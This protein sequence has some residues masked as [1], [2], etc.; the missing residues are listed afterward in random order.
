MPE[1]EGTGAKVSR[2][3]SSNGRCGASLQP[4]PGRPAQGGLRLRPADRAGGAGGVAPDLGGAS[5]R[6]C[7]ARGARARRAP[8]PC[9]RGTRL[10]GGRLQRRRRPASL[11]GR[12]CRRVALAGI[13]PVPPA[14]SRGRGRLLSRRRRRRGAHPA[15]P[16][17]QPPSTR[18]WPMCE[19]RNRPVAPSRSPRRD[20]TTCCWVGRPERENDACQRLGGIC[21]DCRSRR[22]SR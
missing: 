13:E 18:T 5:G 11:S 21:P 14:P 3:P 4:G 20:G 22:L 17:P 8:P 2:V 16:R 7:R 1:R 15:A 19:G 12:V 10:R 9:S 6:A